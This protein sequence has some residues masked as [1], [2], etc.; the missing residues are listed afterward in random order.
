[1]RCALPGAHRFV[2]GCAG[3]CH[4]TTWLSVPMNM[5]LPVPG[6]VTVI[7]ELKS[8]VATGSRKSRQIQGDSLIEL[9]PAASI[10]Q[11]QRL[12]IITGESWTCQT[13]K[14]EGGSRQEKD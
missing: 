6:T 14:E 9:G 1:M 3:S 4:A 13:T 2:G 7:S 8:E 12:K 10:P 5:D 11:P